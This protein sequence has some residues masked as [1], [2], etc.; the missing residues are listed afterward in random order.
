MVEDTPTLSARLRR[1][2]RPK[3]LVFS[4]ISFVAIFAEVTENERIIERHV[5]G[6]YPLLDYDALAMRSQ[7]R[8]SVRLSVK[9]VNC[10]ETKAP[11]EKNSV[12]TNRKATMRFPL[13]SV[14]CT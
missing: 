2:C 6:I 4:D 12:M 5:R 7:S 14:R 9:R 10:D 11:S 3:N 13:N 1:R 8:L